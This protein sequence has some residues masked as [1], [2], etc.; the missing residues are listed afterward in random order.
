M[1]TKSRK[2][3]T[4]PSAEKKSERVNLAVKAFF[5]VDRLVRVGRWIDEHWSQV[6]DW[7]TN[8]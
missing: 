8:L 3:D 1:N 6:T 2:P 5:V 4:S 7:L